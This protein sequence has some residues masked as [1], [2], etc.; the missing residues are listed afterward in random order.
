MNLLET[1]MKALKF[2]FSGGWF[3]AAGVDNFLQ[4]SSFRFKFGRQSESGV[5]NNP[6]NFRQVLQS[7]T[8]AGIFI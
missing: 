2:R 3:D 7:F 4:Y 8:G 6:M 1:N 5:R